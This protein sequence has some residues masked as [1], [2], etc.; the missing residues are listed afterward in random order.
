[1]LRIQ[2]LK[3]VS[4]QHYI[5]WFGRFSSEFLWLSGV[6]SVF[7][8]SVSEAFNKNKKNGAKIWQ[9]RNV[10]WTFEL[11]QKFRWSLITGKTPI[12]NFAKQKLQNT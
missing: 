1:M 2:Q 11:K 6:F 8:F 7:S 3:K 9:K 10:F 5:K 12:T 4:E